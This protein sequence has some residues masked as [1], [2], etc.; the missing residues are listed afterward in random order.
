MIE[1]Y[2]HHYNKVILFFVTFL[3]LSFYGCGQELK[4]RYSLEDYHLTISMDSI[5]IINKRIDLEGGIL[6]LPKGVTLCFLCNSV[7]SNGTIIGNDNSIKGRT[8]KIFDNVEIKG[9][10]KVEEI[11]TGM[12]L[13]CTS[14]KLLSNITNLSSNKVYNKIVIEKDILVEI[15]LW[16]SYLVLKSNTD[17]YLKAKMKAKPSQNKGGWL[18]T[19][20]GENVRIF[21]GGNV[22][23][24]DVLE[25][26]KNKPECLHAIFV[27]RNSNNIVIDNLIMQYFWGDGVSSQ[28]SNIIFENLEM[29]FNGRQGI[30]LTNGNNIHIRNCYFHDMGRKGINE[31][32]G[33]GAGID[34]E[35]GN[36]MTVDDVVISG[37]I[38]TD[39][40]KYKF[41]YVND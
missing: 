19:V 17:L 2:Y 22:L 29:M 35:P 10:W 37:C 18:I 23:Q 20:K 31:D 21:G 34:V 30:T 33:P 3:F 9:L 27:D 13:N 8:Q 11:Y 24:G 40:Y 4:Q 26:K 32:G 12:F 28:G 38:I 16:T 41:D 6:E 14:E 39:N 15:P 7:I 5:C 25:Q 36:D 1:N